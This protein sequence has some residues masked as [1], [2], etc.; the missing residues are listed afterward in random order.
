MERP[1]GQAQTERFDARLGEPSTIILLPREARGSQSID[2]AETV[3]ARPT[4]YT[5]QKTYVADLKMEPADD[6]ARNKATGYS[7]S[8]V[9][10]RYNQRTSNPTYCIQVKRASAGVIGGVELTTSPRLT[11]GTRLTPQNHGFLPLQWDNQRHQQRDFML[12]TTS[13]RMSQADCF[14]PCQLMITVQSSWPFK[15]WSAVARCCSASFAA[16]RIIGL[17]PHAIGGG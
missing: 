1:R 13:R 16:Q 2:T 7:R 4:N 5:H 12:V 3:A 8:G 17:T 15:S 14:H 11:E 9:R 6:A 10:Q